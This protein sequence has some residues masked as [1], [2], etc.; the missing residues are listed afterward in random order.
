MEGGVRWTVLERFHGQVLSPLVNTDG[1]LSVPCQFGTKITKL[2]FALCLPVL[3][4]THTTLYYRV[5]V[6]QYLST[7]GL[8]KF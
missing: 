1:G 3:E 6:N 7:A 8:I 5:L 4:Y 2:F